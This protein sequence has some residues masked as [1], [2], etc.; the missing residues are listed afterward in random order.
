MAVAL[1]LACGAL[2]SASAGMTRKGYIQ[3]KQ[4]T[5]KLSARHSAPPRADGTLFAL[6]LEAIRTTLRKH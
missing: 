2:L 5:M 4:S 6:T 1:V 3:H